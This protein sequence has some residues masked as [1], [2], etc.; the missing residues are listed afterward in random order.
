MWDPWVGCTRWVTKPALRSPRLNFPPELAPG[1][2][3]PTLHP[4]PGLQ[5]A[6]GCGLRVPL[7]SAP[8][9]HCRDLTTG[10][11][12]RKA[13]SAQIPPGPGVPT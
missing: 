4:A 10:E 13:L 8:F 9:H 7:E 1:R 5:I 12:V 2:L 3:V 6:L 11:P